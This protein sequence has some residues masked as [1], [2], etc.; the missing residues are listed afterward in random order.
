MQACV[1]MMDTTRHLSLATNVT[2]MQGPR[3][4]LILW[5]VPPAPQHPGPLGLEEVLKRQ[6]RVLLD[7][8][9]APGRAGGEWA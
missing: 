2:E 4:I 7:S 5:L 9:G 8:S 1:A 3:F 6:T